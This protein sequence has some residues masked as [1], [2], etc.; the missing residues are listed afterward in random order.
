VAKNN[1]I[2]TGEATY[3]DDARCVEV[4]LPASTSNLGAGFDCF[5]LALQL[6]LTVRARIAPRSKIN[7]R[8]RISGGKQGA[9]LPRS[10]E[11]LIYRSMAD[12]AR[13]EG[14][15]LPPV[16]LAIHNEIP[17]SR[18]LGG[19]AAAI[20]AGIKLFELLCEH[21]LPD[22]KVLRYATQFEGHA[23]NVA[24]A[25]LG[26]FIVTCISRRGDIIT[27]KR[28]WPS[29]IKIVV[30]A[31]EL[32]V[33]T[34]LAR[35]ALPRVINHVDGV[36]NL[37]RAALFTAALNEHRYDLLWEAMQD[38]LHQAKRQTLVPGLAEALA[39]PKMPGLL[40]LALSGAGPGVLALAQDNFN[41]I[42]GTIA[43][44]FKQ[45]GINAWVYQL[46]IDSVGYQSRVLREGKRS[47]T[48][49]S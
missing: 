9:S 6:F 16:H 42:G 38:R 45:H 28:P 48:T 5:G 34:K 21:E 4:R 43:G 39:T 8:I 29:D 49:A 30:V 19:S 26:G 41:E 13:R 10:A 31:P 46:E 2:N 22:D 44:P 18:G 1:R 40:G 35:A 32:Q 25:L 17:V 15:N 11:N 3:H 14:F 24:P 33:Q 23:D 20:V 7:C 27:V 36:F 37:Q 47:A 12:T